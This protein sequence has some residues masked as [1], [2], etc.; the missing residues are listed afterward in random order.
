ML[1]SYTSR[2]RP[3][4]YGIKEQQANLSPGTVVD[5]VEEKMAWPGNT[6][7]DDPRMKDIGRWQT[8]NSRSGLRGVGWKLLKTAGWEPDAIEKLISDAQ[9]QVSD[10]TY[11]WF[12]P[13]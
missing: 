13:V 2:N 8:I 7:P 3:T 9:Q 10:E 4:G 5:V 11:R 12:L 6:W 1:E